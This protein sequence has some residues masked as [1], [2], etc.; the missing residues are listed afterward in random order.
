[1]AFDMNK[2]TKVT[3]RSAG[4][5]GYKIPEHSI[6]RTLQVNESIVVPYQELVWLSYQPGGRN[7]LQNML[8]IE[9]AS[10]TQELELH[11]E[12]EYFMNE[13]EV[14]KLLEEGSLD[15]LLDALDF[16]PAGVIDIIK[17]K[18]VSLPLNDVRKRDAIKK[19]TGFDITAA[20]ENAAAEEGED[21]APA[22]QTPT[23]RV[24]KETPAPA[25]RYNVIE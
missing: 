16:A 20:I 11:T 5:V 22:A 4:T 8:L 13:A 23:R 9:D 12:P 6:R 10:A 19:A 18:A 1:M 14:Q 17:S 15:E 24:Q 3:N 2:M 21:E 7:L 25:R